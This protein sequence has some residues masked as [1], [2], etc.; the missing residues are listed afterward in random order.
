M[1]KIII[2]LKDENKRENIIRAQVKTATQS[3]NF[4]GGVRGGVDR[5][6]KSRVK[7]YIQ[8]PEISDIVIGIHPLGSRSFDSI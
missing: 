5:E 6:Y 8:S 7:E 4:T 1:D 2:V 3:I